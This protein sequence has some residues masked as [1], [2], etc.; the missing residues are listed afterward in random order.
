MSVVRFR[1]SPELLALAASAALDFRE[2]FDWAEVQAESHRLTLH[3]RTRINDLTGLESISPDSSE[4]I[5]QLASI[6]LPAAVDPVAL[7]ARLFDEFRIEVPITV[8]NGEPFVRVSFTA[9]TT[10]ADSDALVDALQ[11]LL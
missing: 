5:G 3:T 6:R 2:S 8:W 9:H 1:V 7:K 10:E 11:Q 4:W